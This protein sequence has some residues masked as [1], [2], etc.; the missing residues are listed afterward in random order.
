MEVLMFLNFFFGAGM[1]KKRR[2]FSE[3]SKVIGNLGRLTFA[4][5]VLGSIIKEEFI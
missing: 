2:I 4:N 3:I 1:N 5:L